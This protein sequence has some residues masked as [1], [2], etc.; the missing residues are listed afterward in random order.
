MT[1]PPVG[2]L[3]RESRLLKPAAKAASSAKSL[4]E[5]E[6]VVLQHRDVLD[7]AWPLVIVSAAPPPSVTCGAK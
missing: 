6:C 7:R 4:K 2:Q 3:S 1:A 5:V